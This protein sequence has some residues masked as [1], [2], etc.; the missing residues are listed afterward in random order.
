MKLVTHTQINYTFA[1][2]PA[3]S[4][5]GSNYTHTITTPNLFRRGYTGHEHLDPF[6][7]I[8]MNGR[9]YDPNTASFFSPD[10]Y[11][12]DPSSTQAFNRYAYC[13]NNPLMYTDP[14]GEIFMSLVNGIKDLF[15][16]I[17]NTFKNGFGH[18]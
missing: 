16:N 8:N 7:I 1:F 5:A 3:F 12:V 10:P 14:S 15:T 2:C 17:G 18:K 4:G 6:G 9:L 13:L 11:V